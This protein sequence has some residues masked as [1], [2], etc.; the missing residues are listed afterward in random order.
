MDNLITIYN[1]VV[2][3]CGD[4]YNQTILLLCLI[5]VDTYLG[6]SWRIKRKKPLTSSRFIEGNVLNISVS[7][8]PSILEILQ[9]FRGRTPILTFLEFIMTVT[10]IVFF[11]QSI[12]SNWVL[13]GYKIPKFILDFAKKHFIDEINNKTNK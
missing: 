4:G 13:T 3:F 2:S 7:L 5:V 11:M 1:E 8:I 6:L 10:T 9:H 12:I